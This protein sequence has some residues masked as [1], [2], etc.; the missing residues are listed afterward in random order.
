[1]RT[2]IEIKVKPEDRKALEGLIANRNTPSK[3]GCRAEII[4]ATA[5]GLGTNGIMRQ[6]GKSKACGWRWQEPFIRMA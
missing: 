6:T 1:M 2:G 5:D 3:V 4:L